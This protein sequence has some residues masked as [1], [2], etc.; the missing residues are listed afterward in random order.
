M[1]RFSV[2]FGSNESE[3]AKINNLIKAN[4]E[5]D[6][7]SSEE[8]QKKS[9]VMLSQKENNSKMADEVLKNLADAKLELSTT[10][11]KY[12]DIC[13]DLENCK[14]EFENARE[15]M[16][17]IQQEFENCQNELCE[18]YEKLKKYSEENKETTESSSTRI[19]LLKKQ[20]QIKEELFIVVQ[21]NLKDS[22]EILAEKQL[23]WEKMELQAQ[24]TEDEINIQTDI[25]MSL[26]DKIK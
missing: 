2:N 20:I 11:I 18:L 4:F 21:K 15:A 14:Q 10:K 5:D 3:C 24:E 19:K 16:F 6:N 1:V 17:F 7:K 23:L 25:L 13:I 9:F 26:T 12:S 8:E 22:K